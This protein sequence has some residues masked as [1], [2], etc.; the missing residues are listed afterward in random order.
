MS[1]PKSSF[2]ASYIDLSVFTYVCADILEKNVPDPHS[3]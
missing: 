3:I 1:E 2:T